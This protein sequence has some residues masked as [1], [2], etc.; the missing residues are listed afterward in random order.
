MFNSLV[1]S[2]LRVVVC[3]ILSMLPFHIETKGGVGLGQ[4][5]TALVQPPLES[6]LYQLIPVVI[7]L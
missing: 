5:A 1:F 2:K 6:G 3:P 4:L 7:T